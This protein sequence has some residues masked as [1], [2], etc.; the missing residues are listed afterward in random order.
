MSN[1]QRTPEWFAQRLGHCTASRVNDALATI[2]T[3]ESASRRNYRLQLVA[4]RLTGLQEESFTSPAMLRGTEVEPIARAAYEANHEFV[5]E[6]PFVK[7]STIMW[8]G[9][10]PD[11]LVGTDGLIEI[12]CPN[13]TTHLEYLTTGKV[14][15]QYKNQ[16]MA[17]MAC[18]QRKW[19]DF[20]SFDNRLP[21]NLQLFVVRF[22][23]SESEINSMLE[24]V[25]EFLDEVASEETR[26]RNYTT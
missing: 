5:T 6:A 9:A 22:E 16:M 17:Q 11:G 7:H 20:V 26:L 3:G 24:K 19:C 8:F 1:L 13:T 12:K 2:K 18:T 21:E 4:E 14:P 25:Q 15:N 10:S 23:P